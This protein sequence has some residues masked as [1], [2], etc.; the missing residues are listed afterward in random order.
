M[1]TTAHMEQLIRR[2]YDGCNEADVA[3]MAGCFTPEAVHYFPPGMPGGPFRGAQAIAESWRRVVQKAGARWTIDAL[4]LDPASARAVIEWSNFTNGRNRLVRQ[5]VTVVS[6]PP[7]R[8][9]LDVPSITR[10]FAARTRTVMLAPYEKLIDSGEPLRYGQLS[11]A[12]RLAWL[13]IAAAVAEGL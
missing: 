12:T 2:Y 3:K 10:H 5:A 6:M 11:A 7:S 4:L 9:D 13:R 8:R 1:L